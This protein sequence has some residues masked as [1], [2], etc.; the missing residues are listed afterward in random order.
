MIGAGAAVLVLLGGGG[1]AALNAFGGD[2]TPSDAKS[3]APDDNGG[4]DKNLLADAKVLIDAPTAK[5]LTTTGSWAVAGTADGSNA[6]DKSFVCQAQRF[7]DPAGIR[8]WVRTLRNAATR[9]TAVQ[10]V[11]V[12]NDAAAAAKSYSTITGWLSQ[13]NTPQV[14]LVAS[15]TTQGLGD[16]GVIAVFGQPNGSK[17]NKYRT[18]S[19]TTAGQATMV[20]E[21]AGSGGNPPKP[22]GVLATASAGLKRICAQTGASCGTAAPSVR[23]ALLPTAES[24]GFMAPIDLPVLASVDKPWVSVTGEVRSGTLC[25]K[26]DLKKA[27]ATKSRT[28]TYVVPEAQVPTEFGLDATVAKFATPATASAFV[29]QIRKNVDGCPKTTSNA[30]VKSTGS[31]SQSGVRGEAWKATYDTGGG[32]VFTY[33]IGI[34]GAG[35]RAVYL[36]YPVLKNLDISD[37][38]F[39]DILSRAAERSATF[40]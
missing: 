31:L 4:G 32:K 18:V 1:I 30:T 21:H 27:K 20:L 6:P 25:E 38:A 11:E 14:R 33:R 8:T 28:Q 12:S 35:D 34:A 2:D 5:P 10:Y 9:D 39:T 23:P 3:S 15:Y 24:A 16:R 17:S 22:D 29:T 19:V 40:K 26:I 13:C 36:L 37:S 7:A